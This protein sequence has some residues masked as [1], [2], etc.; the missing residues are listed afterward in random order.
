MTNVTGHL[1]VSNSSTSTSAP[2]FGDSNLPYTPQLSR[3]RSPNYA[4]TVEDS[5]CGSCITPLDWPG[6]FSL[7]I[8]PRPCRVDLRLRV[9]DELLATLLADSIDRL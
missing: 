7:L 9:T 8:A 3:S 2:S 1:V 5:R 6:Y 4:D